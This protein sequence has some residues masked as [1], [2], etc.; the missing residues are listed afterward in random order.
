METDVKNRLDSV[1]SCLFEISISLWFLRFK[2]QEMNL[3]VPP[4]R[5]QQR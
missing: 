2:R 1:D 3:S 5:Y 4:K